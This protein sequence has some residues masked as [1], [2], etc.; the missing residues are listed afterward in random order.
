MQ[1]ISSAAAGGSLVTLS[2]RTGTRGYIQCPVCKAFGSAETHRVDCPL[3]QRKAAQVRYGDVVIV[4]GL[5]P[6][7]VTGTA[8]GG[9]GSARLS[10]MD[11]LGG[12]Q[13][14]RDYPPFASV[15]VIGRAA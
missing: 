13:E 4:D 9:H 8:R 3:A 14:A 10:T 6:A 7:V 15:T 12:Y 11:V 5:W 1:T 2:A